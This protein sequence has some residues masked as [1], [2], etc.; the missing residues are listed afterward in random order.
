MPRV[1]P[2]ADGMPPAVTDATASFKIGDR[3][4]PIQSP[5]LCRRKE[6]SLQGFVAAASS[7]SGGGVQSPPAA[8]A[9]VS[10]QTGVALS[11]NLHKIKFRRRTVSPG[12]P[13]T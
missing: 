1:A 6:L 2:L 7:R 10:F 3:H 5:V 8:T 12:V 13:M 9:G 11:G 4:G